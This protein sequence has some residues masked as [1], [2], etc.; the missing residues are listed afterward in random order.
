MN[1]RFPQLH[2]GLKTK[3]VL[4]ISFLILITSA[5]LSGFLTERQSLLIQK[6][7]EK[8]GESMVRNLAHNSEYGVLVENKPLLLNLMEGLYQEEEVVYIVIKDK[9]GNI[10]ADWDRT[11]EYYQVHSQRLSVDKQILTEEPS[12]E[13]FVAHGKEFYDFSCPIKTTRVER[14]KEEV[15]LILEDK[16][17]LVT[18]KKKIGVVQIGMSLQHMRKDIADMKRIIV[19][20]TFLVVAVG[21]LLTIFLVNIFIRPVKRLVHATERVA[22][23]D[24]SQMV[25]VT[26]KDEIGTLA[27]SFNRM[28]ISLKESRQKI[29]EYNRTLES[30]VKERTAE[31]EKTTKLLQ[32]EYDRLE[33]I[34]N[35]PN[36]G[37]VIEDKDCNI[38]FMNK[39]LIEIFG[40]Q[41]GEKC[42]EKFK[43]RKEKC[44]VCPIDEILVKGKG[45]FTYLDQ[46]TQ[47][48][49]YELSAALFQDEKGERC[50][51]ET[52][53]DITEQKKLEQQVE[54][55]TRSLE[56]TNR[57]LENALK[58]LKETQAQLIQMEKMAAVGQL[59]AGVAHELNNPLGGI[60]G[61]SQ[62]ALEKIDQKPI[63]QFDEED[64]KSFLQYLKDIERQT[65]RCRSIIQSLLKFSRASRKE[66]FEPTD[67]N[68]ILKETF[69]FT[70]HQVEKNR[71]R[72][73]EKL[74]ESLPL[75]NGH[76]GQLQ[77]VFTNL[78]LNAVQAMPEGGT[79]TVVSRIGED[80]KVV[81]ISFTDTGVGISEENLGKIFEPFFTSKKVGEGTGL[82]LSVS[83]GLIKNHG[84][85]IKVKSKKNQGTTFSV[86]LPLAK[87]E[88]A[89]DS[90]DE[91]EIA[92]SR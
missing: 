37:I 49:Y 47:G 31:L 89:S 39:S 83:Y 76:S 58:S 86:I 71:V 91:R 11:K 24:L 53:R 82:G 66:E 85:E 92:I 64:T 12:K 43:G 17:E 70:R 44:P 57:E 2:L 87:K 69:M 60:L 45:A 36:L 72:L 8:R 7:L 20:L 75:I 14:S 56:K 3:F 68:T 62:F 77:Q 67:V 41:I 10:L 23:G 19:L 32:V 16:K 65:K 42:Y 9:K 6:E 38:R 73:V 59:A 26:T 79:L 5:I 4:I 48:H 28:T 61:Y 55:Y 63:R 54:E 29:E 51:L 81:E 88:T 30:K 84:G 35:S 13:Y 21:V 18:R 74:A 90:K 15:G 1:I 34:I 25:K 52:L 40:N 27:S 22:S 78:I 33:A 50:I 80:L 46:D